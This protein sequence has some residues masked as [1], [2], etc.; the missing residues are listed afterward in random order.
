[1]RFKI[2]IRKALYEIGSENVKYTR[3]LLTSGNRTGRVY[4]F[5]GRNHRA[6][7]PGEAPANR[8]GRL[9]RSIDYI[10]RSHKQMEFGDKVL[11]G[12]FLE[13]GTSKMEPRPHLKTTVDKLARDAQETL[14]SWVDKE[15]K[16]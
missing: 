14:N 4:R 13:L 16:R 5:R 8:S 3:R 11:Y 12:K 2:G 15:I 6:S 7:A 9:L 1:M 10:V